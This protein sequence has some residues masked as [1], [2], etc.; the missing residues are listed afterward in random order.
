MTEVEKV[1]HAC[2]TNL[3]FLYEAVLG[4][5]RYNAD[6]HFDFPGDP[7]GPPLHPGPA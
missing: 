3:R 6:L 2:K 1:Q 7:A 4:Y 5:N